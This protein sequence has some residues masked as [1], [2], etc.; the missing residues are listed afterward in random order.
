MLML[1]TIYE[2]KNFYVYIILTYIF[3]IEIVCV[4]LDF[5]IEEKIEGL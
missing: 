4:L 2:C 1:M 5:T 3:I